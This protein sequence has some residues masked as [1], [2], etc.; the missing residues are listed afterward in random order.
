M[1]TLAYVIIPILVGQHPPHRYAL[2]KLDV[3]YSIPLVCWQ[4][5]VFHARQTCKQQT[6]FLK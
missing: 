3:F 1:V 2:R 6:H 4:E 5:I